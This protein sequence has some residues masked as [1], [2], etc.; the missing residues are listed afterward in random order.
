M[1]AIKS[2]LSRSGP[3][4]SLARGSAPGRQDPGS[5]A[6]ALREAGDHRSPE[7]RPTSPS[8]PRPPTPRRH[9]EGPSAGPQRGGRRAERTPREGVRR[10]EAGRREQIDRR[11]DATRRD[12]EQP[13]A[14]AADDA[15]RPEHETK[16]TGSIERDEA[17]EGEG[18]TDDALDGQTQADA[19]AAAL[20]LPFPTV[21]L[22]A[23]VAES[24]AG[25]AAPLSAEGDPAD[26]ATPG[27]AAAPEA[28]TL[29][30]GVPESASDLDALADATNDA[31]GA[32][33]LDPALSADE[34]QLPSPLAE[35]VDTTSLADAAEPGAE[36][37]TGA[38]GQAGDPAAA[39][40]RAAFQPAGA[41]ATTPNAAPF[42]ALQAAMV[43]ERE[44]AAPEAEP[45]PRAAAL[46]PTAPL[47][48]ATP[49]LPRDPAAPAA[50]SAPAPAAAPPPPSLVDQV[51]V[52]IR[53][54]LNEAHITLSPPELGRVAVR[55]LLRDGVLEARVE[56]ETQAARV[57][58][59]RHRHDLE[60][61]LAQDGAPVRVEVVQTSHGARQDAPFGQQLGQ[62]ADQRREP[63]GE[64]LDPLTRAASGAPSRPAAG[65]P[66][67][68]A[69]AR[70]GAG[71]RLDTL[72]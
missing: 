72:A 42:A 16:E 69:P 67:Q 31:D 56:A 64:R 20:P 8:D 65:G 24:V 9:G 21:I 68:P 71:L 50:I 22:A 53:P 60:T 66:H 29:A 6:Q 61:A 48:G 58:L 26:G 54:G 11:E 32:F 52:A 46:D 15:A 25:A 63:P 5:F 40:D 59:E 3:A 14:P 19:S 4:E 44:A 43:Q 27:L 35:G 55:L 12:Q 62:H 47:P 70:S 57:T 23:T 45:R 41:P 7:P 1:D 18:P 49:G 37:Q 39:L 17:P 28:A 33:A 30:A 10:E 36:G 34:D 2:L 38:D 13:G 51:R